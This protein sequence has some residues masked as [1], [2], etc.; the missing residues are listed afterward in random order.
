MLPLPTAAP[1]ALPRW[2]LLP[3]AVLAF[4][5]LSGV[6]ALRF[7]YSKCDTREQMAVM[8]S[9]TTELFK[10][11]GVEYWLD[12]GTLL[13]IH[14]DD[15][16]IPW[17]YD[18]DIGVMNAT[19]DQISALKSEFQAVGLVAYDRRDYIPHKVKLTYDTE[20]HHFYWSDP[21]LHDPCI[22]VYDSSDVSTWV[23]VYW[24]VELEA[25]QVAAAGEG[26]VLVPPGYDGSDSL[27]CCSE[28]LQEYT[29]HMCCGG[30]VPKGSLFPLKRHTVM[31][32]D[33]VEP[34]QD[35]YLPYDVPQFLSI[36]YGEKALTT[37]E[38]K[39]CT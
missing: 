33:G 24:Y 13:G 11:H 10:R 23:D 26:N 18:V 7:L 35:Q 17:E 39:V 9:K 8:L 3:L 20:N 30:C 22:R 29:E 25:A 36:Q 4:V 38:I 28:G 37:R 6:Y 16:L 31:V 27:V 5:V 21:H 14:R 2:R 12:K 32:P 34:V 15:G 1:A 19:C